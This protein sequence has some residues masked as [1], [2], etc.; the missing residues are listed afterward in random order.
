ME[1][2]NKKRR[3]SMDLADEEVDGIW[4]LQVCLPSGRCET[5]SISKS[6]T[7]LDLK[8]A[9]RESLEQRFLKLAAPDGHL[10]DLTKSLELSGLQDGDNITAVAQQPKIAATKRAFALWCVGA[11][12]VV[13]WGDSDYGGDCAAVAGQLSDVQQVR[14]THSAFAAIL[15]DGS[16][17]TWGEPEY[18]GDCAEVQDQLRSVK[19]IHA[20]EFAFAAILADGTVVTWGDPGLVVTALQSKMS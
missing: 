2:E 13:T 5:I 9:V 16:V 8:I 11:D 15:A 1:R 17:V 18:G 20:T 12:R 14:A 3:V 6:N 7:V 10:L 19:Q 4:N